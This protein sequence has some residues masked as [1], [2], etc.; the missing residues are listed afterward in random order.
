ME[1]FLNSVIPLAYVA[2]PHEKHNN[3]ECIAQPVRQDRGP[4]IAAGEKIDA[5]EHKAGICRIKD[6]RGTF[7]EMPKTED[8]CDIPL[9]GKG[10]IRFAGHPD[11]ANSQQLTANSQEPRAKSQWLKATCH[12]L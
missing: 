11:V 12:L 9:R 1:G 7:V 6:T 2:P 8:D 4:Q 10:A 3:G 5:S